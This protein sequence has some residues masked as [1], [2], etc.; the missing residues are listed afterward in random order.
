MNNPHTNDGILD[1]EGHRRTKWIVT[2]HLEWNIITNL[3]GT[4][5]LEVEEHHND[6]DDDNDTNILDETIEAPHY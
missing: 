2:K 1:I 5:T 6:D 3:H 4:N